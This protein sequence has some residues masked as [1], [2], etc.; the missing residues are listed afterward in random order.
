MIVTGKLHQQGD[1]LTISVALVDVREHSQLWGNRYQG[2]LSGILD[3]Q[4][5]IA[6]DVAA[7]LRLRLSGEED[8][9]LTKRDTADPE[10][11]LL[12]REAMHHFNRFTEE[13]LEKG[14]EYCQRAI[15]K[16]PNYALAYFGLGRCHSLLG[17]IHRGPRSTNAAEARKYFAEALKIDGTLADAHSWL[18]GGYM[19]LDWDWRAAERELKR[20][21]ELSAG[22]SS[23]DTFLFQ[24]FYEA[25][26][27]R[28]AEALANIRRAQELDPLAAPRRY[29]LAMA[30]NWLRQYDQAIAEAER[31]LEL[32]P[33][34]PLAYAELGSALVQKELPEEAIARLNKAVSLGQKHPRVRGM[35]GYAYAM[36]GKKN[37]SQKLL[38]ELKG[39]SEGRFGFALSIA[40]IHAALGEKD[41]AFEWL[42]KACV[43]RDPVVIWLK[44]DPTLDSLR[45]DPRFAQVLRDMGL[46]L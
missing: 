30:N 22:E 7:N 29:E 8:Q 35:L 37:E 14:I 9:R 42:R 17:A 26:N 43:E 19:G 5:K 21:F 34:F 28:P 12:Y 6:R 11:Y 36:A 27:G 45:S 25:A 23:G 16:D 39:Q 2:K 33:N 1:D 41:Q 20:A 4:D 40:R 31:A 13:G 46:P 38:A 15:K 32:E 24:G 18:A 3:M 10:A 44:V